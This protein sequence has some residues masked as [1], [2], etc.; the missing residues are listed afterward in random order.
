MR[1][2]ISGRALYYPY[3]GHLWSR[4]NWALGFRSIGCSVVWLELVDP[5]KPA[6]ET[7]AGAETLF[8][9]LQT[10]GIDFAL[11][12]PPESSPL[13][14]IVSLEDAATSDILLNH[15]VDIG[16]EILAHFR[17]T[18]FIDADPG[19]FQGWLRKGALSLSAHDLYFT[20]GEGAAQ[21]E[22]GRLWQYIPQCIALDWWPVTTDSAEGA[23][24]TVTHWWGGRSGKRAGF[25]PYFDL[26]SLTRQPLEISLFVER[27]SSGEPSDRTKQEWTNLTE[28]G[29][30]LRDA[31]TL[32]DSAAY[33]RYIQNSIGEFS[34]AKPDYVSMDTA[35]VSDRT[36]CYLASGKPAI[37]QHTGPSKVLPDSGGVF[38]FRDP[39]EAAKYLDAAVKDYDRNARL[40]RA[41]AEEHFDAKK[42]VSRVLEISA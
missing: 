1:V 26:P 23:F 14:G 38:R 32:W 24:T 37:V 36:L 16:T 19:M 39:Q 15:D 3:N 29:W 18:I 4:L 9:I 30:R 40:A 31:R 17:R 35:W 10:Y 7:A 22:G 41:I 33:Q 27:E 8:R 5:E 25:E 21:K 11:V 28:R 20:V 2:C 34:C 12:G 13:E 6:L 42:V